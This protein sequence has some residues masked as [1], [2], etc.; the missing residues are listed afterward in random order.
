MKQKE[1]TKTFMM[2][3]NWQNPLF[4]MV[5]FK[6]ISALQGLTSSVFCMERLQEISYKPFGECW[7]NVWHRWPSTQTCLLFVG[8]PARRHWF[9]A[10]PMSDTIS[11]ALKHR[12]L[13]AGEP[14][15]RHCFSAGPISGTVGPPLASF[16]CLQASQPEVVGL[17]L[18][19]IMAELAQHWDSVICL[20]A[21]EPARSR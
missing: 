17:M 9:S 18:G 13:F 21:G 10:G 2:F 20:P 5:Y 4:S 3:T 6:N 8:E 15:K 16:F 14:A 1:L 19:Q 12:L 7:A 11:P